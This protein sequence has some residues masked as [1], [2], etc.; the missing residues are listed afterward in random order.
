MFYTIVLS[1]T[2]ISDVF[3]RINMIKKWWDSIKRGSIGDNKTLT[4]WSCM[5]AEGERAM[6]GEMMVPF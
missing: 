4:R 6:D 3:T 1:L 5:L 2:C